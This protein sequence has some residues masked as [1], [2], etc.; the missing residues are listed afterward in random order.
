M[1]RCPMRRL[2]E[3][4]T[5]V[6]TQLPQHPSTK[7]AGSLGVVGPSRLGLVGIAKYVGIVTRVAPVVTAHA[8]SMAPTAGT[9]GAVSKHDS[10]V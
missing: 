3:R 7:A 10:G 2:I 5:H 9:P 4:W 8:L 1:M 6:A